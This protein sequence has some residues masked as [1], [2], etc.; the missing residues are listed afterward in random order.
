MRAYLWIA[1][2]LLQSFPCPASDKAPAPAEAK[3]VIDSPAELQVFQR[4]RRN[5]GQVKVAGKVDVA[6][7]SVQVRFSG[8]DVDGKPLNAEWKAVAYSDKDGGFG[9]LITMGAGGWHSAE[10]RALKS[11]KAIATAKVARFG[12]GEVFIGAGQSNSTNCGG[13]GSRDPGDGR[14]VALSG[15][16]STFD[17]KVWRVAD[18][19]QPGTHDNS[20]NGSFWPAFG[21]T[22][23]ARYH[24]PIGVAVTGHSGTSIN[25]WKSGGELFNWTLNRVRQ[26][27]SAG[28]GPGF[29]AL[30]WHQGESDAEMKGD[31]YAAGL[32]AIIREMRRQSHR[33]FPW[34]VAKASYRPG[35]PLAAPVTD[36]QKA[37]WETEVAL[38]GP[39]TDA[40]LG[41]LRDH[42]GTGIHFSRKGLSVHGAAWADKVG[43]WLDKELT[44]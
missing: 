26:L 32:G 10:V 20:Q 1:L 8:K 11:G 7:D 40:M 28:N 12:I 15:K 34:F 24:V 16:V 17:G 22:M 13:A 33:D 38:E 25:Q 27:E 23:A 30:L 41:E 19:P 35:K 31:A 4:A 37:L 36:G 29:R 21:D 18:D 2:G 42:G 6:C 5:E 44:R 14:L 9:G 43:A 39:D 3:L